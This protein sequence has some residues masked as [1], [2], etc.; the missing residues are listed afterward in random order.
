VS[1]LQARL[2][3]SVETA[4]EL[5]RRLASVHDFYDRALRSLRARRPP[6]HGASSPPSPS[7]PRGRGG[8]ELEAEWRARL[9][10][11]REAR[12]RAVGALEARLRDRDDEI[13]RLSS[14]LLLPSYDE[15]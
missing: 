12:R 9:D 10:R 5:R 2:E 6:P 8:P 11:A 14:G 1:E 7:A 15:I 4:D 3:A 13:E